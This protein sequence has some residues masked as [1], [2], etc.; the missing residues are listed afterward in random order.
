MLNK[1]Y[2]HLFTNLNKEN[3]NIKTQILLKVRKI[4]AIK[5]YANK[6]LQFTFV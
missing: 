5:Y 3:Q 1:T 4:N 2:D 6:Y